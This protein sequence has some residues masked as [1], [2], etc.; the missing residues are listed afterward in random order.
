MLFEFFFIIA[1]GN[2]YGCVDIQFPADFQFRSQKVKVQ[3]G[4]RFVDLCGVIRPSM[5]AF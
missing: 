1:R 2:I 3:S 4:M 5:M